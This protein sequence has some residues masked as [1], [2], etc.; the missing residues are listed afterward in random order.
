VMPVDE[1]LVAEIDPKLIRRA[2]VDLLLNALQALHESDTPNPTV[3]LRAEALP[4]GG[5]QIEVQDNGPGISEEAQRRIFQPF[6][7]TR[8]RGSGIGLANVQKV[9][10]AHGGTIEHVATVREGT[11]FRL[12]LPA[13]EPEGG[14]S[15]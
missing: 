13:A 8:D 14:A 7:T 1:S 9:V 6:F 15:V 11:C 12:S 4:D 3:W 2:L 10:S 5:T